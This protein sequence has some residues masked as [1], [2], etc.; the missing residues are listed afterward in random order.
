MSGLVE[1]FLFPL[2]RLR[3]RS[4]LPGQECRTEHNQRNTQYRIRRYI[5]ETCARARLGHPNDRATRTGAYTRTCAWVKAATRRHWG[6]LIDQSA[7]TVV[8]EQLEAG[9]T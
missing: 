2:L 4:T 3:L 9:S 6:W 8:V 1:L 7:L 5:G